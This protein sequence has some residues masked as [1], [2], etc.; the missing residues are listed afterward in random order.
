MQ[1]IQAGRLTR[2]R[3]IHQGARLAYVTPVVLAVMQVRPAFAG[4]SFED[5][6]TKHPDGPGRGNPGGGGSGSNGGPGTN[7]PPDTTPP[8]SNAGSGPGTSGGSGPGPQGGAGGS[9][10]NSGSSG[11]GGAGG[12]SSS[13]PGGPGSG[14]SGGGGSAGGGSGG[15]SDNAAFPPGSGPGNPGTTSGPG[16]GTPLSHPDGGPPVYGSIPSGPVGKPGDAGPPTGMAVPNA[17]GTGKPTAPPGGTNAGAPPVGGNGGSTEVRGLPVTGP[18]PV[19]G[20]QGGTAGTPKAPAS[21]AGTSRTVL[22]STLPR[23]GVGAAATKD[24]GSRFAGASAAQR[25][26]WTQVGLALALL[27]PGAGR[28][29][30]TAARLR[31][32]HTAVRRLAGE[33]A[34]PQPGR[35]G[36]PGAGHAPGAWPHDHPDGR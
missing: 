12:G 26:P 2:R 32:L 25:V 29:L 22:P 3:L 10:G 13:G 7:P 15:P 14:G 34:T 20:V 4:P 21:V 33:D 17:P 23:T 9:G 31:R 19:G 11:N 18:Q 28:V 35:N 5:E 27:L 6:D 24:S 1:D 8:G 16:D 36:R 30:A